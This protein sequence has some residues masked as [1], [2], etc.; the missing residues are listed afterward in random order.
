MNDKVTS[1]SSSASKHFTSLTYSADG[2]CVLAGGRSK[3]VCIYH[4][5]S[6]VLLKKFQVGRWV[7]DWAELQ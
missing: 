5:E 7:V 6:K 1:S 2:S 3:F 4:V